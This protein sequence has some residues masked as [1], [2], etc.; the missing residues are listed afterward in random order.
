MFNI[1]PVRW[2]ADKEQLTALDTSFTTDHI[3]RVINEDLTF[4]LVEEAVDPPLHK[5][6]DLVTDEGDELKLQSLDYILVAEQ[7]DQIVGMA[8][9]DYAY[10]NRRLVLWHLYVAPAVRGHGLGTTLLE[11]VIGYA[12]GSKA[13]CV[14]AETQ[15]INVPA[16]RFYGRRGFRLCG[17][18]TRLYD[19]TG[20]VGGETALFFALDLD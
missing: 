20:P 4:R 19:P 8:A 3:Y 1:R 15:N 18:D 10:W 6:Y 12:R 17:L 11:S 16:I 5:R 7:D 2:P 9:A 13:R 14:W